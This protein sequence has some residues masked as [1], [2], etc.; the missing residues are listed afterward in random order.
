MERRMV[1]LHAMGLSA[2][3]A[4]PALMLAR[5]M[6]GKGSWREN[7]TRRKYYRSRGP[8]KYASEAAQV[9]AVRRAAR[10]RR[11]HPGEKAPGHIRDKAKL[12]GITLA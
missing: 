4:N 12:A 9:V 2:M 8:A 10:W 5:A 11:N 6:V 1:N 3:A 7:L